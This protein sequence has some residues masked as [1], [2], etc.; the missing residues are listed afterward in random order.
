MNENILQD[1]EKI[2]ANAN[3]D[4]IYKA[5]RE[6][7]YAYME[8]HNIAAAVYEDNE[9]HRTPAVRYLTGH[10]SDAILILTADRKSR[11]VPWDENLAALRAHSDFVTPLTEY[12]R[13][14]TDAVKGELKKF[15]ANPKG[16]TV[17]LQ[18]ETTYISFKKFQD[19]L[20][21]DGWKVECTEEGVHKFTKELR[22]VKDEYE[23]ACTVKACAITSGMTDVIIPLLAEGKIKTESDVALFIEKTLREKGCERTSFDTLAAGPSRSYAIH[24]FPGYTGGLWGCDGL[25][26][27]D[28]GVCYEGYASDCTITIARGKLNAAQEK[29]LDLVQVAAD[30]CR[31]LYKKGLT[32]LDAAKKADEIFAKEGLSMPHGLGHGTGL[33]IHEA[34]FVS[35]RAKEDTLFKSGNIVTLEPGL[36]DPQLGGC[37]LENDVLVTDDGNLVLTNSRIFRM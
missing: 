13:V 26:I 9:D 24:A 10:P 37:R 12:K 33:E 22:A 3:L 4:S 29:I 30:E 36:Y 34:P 20:G 19:A 1:Y 21:G 18:T 11:L 17:S 5:R 32:V 8:Q 2:I 28:Y 15:L 27:L 7:V 31:P 23:I 6:K 16:L 25:S 35:M 14:N